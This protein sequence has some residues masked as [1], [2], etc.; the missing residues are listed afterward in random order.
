MKS[1]QQL[2]AAWAGVGMALALVCPMPAQEVDI[3][4]VVDLLAEQDKG[5]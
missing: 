4:I 5:P 2:L 3:Q 1:S